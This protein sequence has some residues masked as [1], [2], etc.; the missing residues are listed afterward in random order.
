MV[1]KQSWRYT[2]ARLNSLNTDDI[3]AF[4]TVSLNQVLNIVLDV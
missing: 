3:R 1:A 4:D 2:C